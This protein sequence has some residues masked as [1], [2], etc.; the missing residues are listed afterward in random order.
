MWYN[1][2]MDKIEYINRLSLMLIGIAV[3]FSVGGLVLTGAGEILFAVG[4]LGLYFIGFGLNLI[5]ELK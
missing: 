1:A 3:G 2:H 4:A 5:S